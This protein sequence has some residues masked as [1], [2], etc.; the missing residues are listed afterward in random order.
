MVWTDE[1]KIWL[2]PVASDDIS[3]EVEWHV[4]IVTRGRLPPELRQ[5]LQEE[6]A[7]RVLLQ[8]SSEAKCYFPSDPFQSINT[9]D[10]AVRSHPGV[11]VAI[12]NNTAPERLFQQLVLHRRMLLTSTN[13][14]TQRLHRYTRQMDG[15]WSTVIPSEG[16]AAI[17]VE[18]LHSWMPESDSA[19]DWSHW[20]LETASRHRVWVEMDQNT[21]ERGLQYTVR[22]SSLPSLKGLFPVP[23]SRQISA[24]PIKIEVVSES[25]SNVAWNSELCELPHR[26]ACYLRSVVSLDEPLFRSALSTT[27]YDDISLQVDYHLYSAMTHVGTLFTR[28]QTN[29]PVT[30]HQH[31][32]PILQPQWTSLKV[33]TESGQSL[34]WSN[35]LSHDIIFDTDGVHLTYGWNETFSMSLQFEPRFWSLDSIP[36]DP[37]RGIE[38]PPLV[39]DFAQGSFLSSKTVLLLPPL[40]D[41]SMPFN[42]LSLSCT[43][44]AFI[45]GSTMSL[46][47]RKA[48]QGVQEDLDPSKKRPTITQALKGKS[49][50]LLDKLRGKIG[51][52][53]VNS[54]GKPFSNDEVTG[55]LEN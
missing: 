25:L 49:M 48:S 1:R 4:R 12:A 22:S 44:Y 47:I 17:S 18:G 20:L 54:K 50:V 45:I 7:D 36:G 35:L 41:L 26:D 38:L 8:A 42:V 39:V 31:L 34:T 40:P 21:I 29:V 23:L 33:Q 2:S 43:L 6:P 32:P 10:W 28:I 52:I 37:N 19:A 14:Q 5:L 16:S 46:L 24:D 15:V 9:Q 27:S 3:N 30:V 53:S 51:L 11:T 55:P 13:T